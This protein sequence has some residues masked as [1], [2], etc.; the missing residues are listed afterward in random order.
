MEARGKVAWPRAG[1]DIAA[2]VR[3]GAA[4]YVET[5]DKATLDEI[6]AR[7]QRHRAGSMT[8]PIRYG[9]EDGYYANINPD[10]LATFWS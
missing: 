5:L 7:G 6:V 2:R 1:F 3:A 8:V 4:Q 9:N 10:F